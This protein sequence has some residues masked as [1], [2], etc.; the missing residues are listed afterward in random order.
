MLI[1]SAKLIAKKMKKYLHDRDIKYYV[2]NICHQFPELQIIYIAAHRE[3]NTILQ[4]P[5]WPFV[6]S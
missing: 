3:L 5:D 2:E 4:E 6:S 1:T